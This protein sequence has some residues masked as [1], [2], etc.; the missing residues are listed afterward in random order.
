MGHRRGHPWLT[1]LTVT[2]GPLA[3]E[4]FH[5]KTSDRPKIGT[6]ATVQR[7]ADYTFHEVQI[8]SLGTPTDAMG[9]AKWVRQSGSYQPSRNN[10]APWMGK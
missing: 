4:R 9:A 3:G 8:T 10:E 2:D 7:T 5:A 1:Y 6:L